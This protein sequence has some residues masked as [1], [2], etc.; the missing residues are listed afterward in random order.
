MID[1][2][3][4][5]G[6]NFSGHE[7]MAEKILINL[8]T[9][10]EIYSRFELTKLKVSKYNSILKLVLFIRMNSKVFLIN[11]SPYGGLLEKIFLRMKRCCIIEY[12]PFPELKEMIDR[13]HHRLMRLLNR[14]CVSKRILI[15]EWQIE[16][17]AVKSTFILKNII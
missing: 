8:D 10:A 5:I 9:N 14:I 15:E 13:P 1:K 16:H 6:T 2:V 3:I 12:T 17:S 4:F 11:G 7:K